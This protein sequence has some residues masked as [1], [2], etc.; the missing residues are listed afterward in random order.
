M[1]L[2][3]Q[4]VANFLEGVNRKF[5]ARYLEFLI[6]E[7]HEE[8]YIYHDRLAE[9]YLRMTLDAKKAGDAG[10][11]S[12]VITAVRLVDIRST[13]SR[14]SAYGKLL[15]FTDN[16]THFRVDRLLGILPSDGM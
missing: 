12:Q 4:L 9:L 13:D 16:T 11:C 2:P 14:N 10:L 5:C 15:L 7:R 3:Q 6:E 8:S 1:E